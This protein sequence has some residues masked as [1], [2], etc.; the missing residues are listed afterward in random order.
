MTSEIAPHIWLPEPKLAFHPE[1]ASDRDIHPL[2]G[3]LRYGHYSSGLVPEPEEMDGAMEALHLCE[4][5]DLVQVVEDVGWRG[6][7]IDRRAGASKGS[8]DADHGAA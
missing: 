2:R 6:V 1:R 5:V 3:L 4:S 8:P 7:R